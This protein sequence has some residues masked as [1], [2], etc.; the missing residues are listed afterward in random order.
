MRDICSSFLNFENITG[1]IEQAGGESP[2]EATQ[3]FYQLLLTSI[4][5]VLCGF[6]LAQLQV[7]VQGDILTGIT[8]PVSSRK[9]YIRQKLR[10]EQ[11]TRLLLSR[12]HPHTIQLNRQSPAHG[13]ALHLRCSM[14]AEELFSNHSQ[15]ETPALVHSAVFLAVFAAAVS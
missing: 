2:Q 6:V 8:N 9:Q 3:A 15:C 5:F 13:P 7:Q 11:Q 4:I 12:A 14:E 1:H 10:S